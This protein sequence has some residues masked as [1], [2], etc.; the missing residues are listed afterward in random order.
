MSRCQRSCAIYKHSTYIFLARTRRE[1]KMFKKTVTVD[2]MSR[3]A[4]VFAGVESSALMEPPRPPAPFFIVVLLGLCRLSFW[5][6]VTAACRWEMTP[7]RSHLLLLGALEASR[8][9]STGP[10]ASAPCTKASPTSCT[11]SNVSHM[12][13]LYVRSVPVSWHFDLIGLFRSFSPPPALCAS[14]EQIK[15]KGSLGDR[16]PVGLIFFH[17]TENS[18][19]MNYSTRGKGRR[20]GLLG[21][22][23]T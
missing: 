21:S 4:N 6:T 8:R 11:S 1:K 14:G 22:I 9:R 17:G 7:R 15:E 13:Y 18:A 5:L 23:R 12:I 19:V 16:T 20:G 10:S 3:H 2:M